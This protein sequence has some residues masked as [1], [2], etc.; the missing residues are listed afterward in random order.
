MPAERTMERRRTRGHGTQ[1]Q[2]ARGTAHRVWREKSQA[3][4]CGQD[5]EKSARMEPEKKCHRA[6]PSNM[7]NKEAW[8]KI[9][10]DPRSPSAQVYMVAPLVYISFPGRTGRT[11]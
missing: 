1:S 11:H 5:E 4:T 10:S 3:D 2:R 7:H 6:Q 9:S 8:H